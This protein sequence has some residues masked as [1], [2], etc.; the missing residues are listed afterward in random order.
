MKYETLITE[1][2]FVERACNFHCQYCTAPLKQITSRNGVLTLEERNGEVIELDA[3]KDKRL[4]IKMREHCKKALEIFPS[5]ILSLIGG[6]LTLIR[7]LTDY[8]EEISSNYE[9]VILTTNGSLLDKKMIEELSKCKKLLL[10]FSIDGYN[11]EMNS[12]RVSNEKMS[13]RILDNLRCCLENGIKVEVQMVLHDRNIEHIKEYADYLFQY[14]KEGYY[15]K[16]MPFPVRWTQGKYSPY[17]SKLSQLYQLFDEY[18]NYQD[19][20]PPKAYLA[21]LLEA[22]ENK[23][24]TTSC[25]APYY[26]NGIDSRGRIKGCTCMPIIYS[27]IFADTKKARLDI[28]ESKEAY[29]LRKINSGFCN[30]CY[31][32]SWAMLNA[33]LRGDIT[34][35]ELQRMQI[36]RTEGVIE[37]LDQIKDHYFI[38]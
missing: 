9:L 29:K 8:I 3:G 14:S 19:V 16:L 7:G 1:L 22:L 20:L 12:Y 21:Y 32:G 35:Y 13:N 37:V 23:H 11:Y 2:L 24:R 28:E 30:T 27:D 31:E 34:K 33:Y 18:E 5:P 26:I 36:G 15:I 4:G 38:I 25:Y 17:Q 6:E 10:Y